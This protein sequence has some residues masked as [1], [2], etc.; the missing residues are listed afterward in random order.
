MATHKFNDTGYFTITLIAFN[1][2]CSDTLEK[3]HY[4]H[5]LPPTAKFTFENS[6]SD[7][8]SV[9]FKDKSL[10][11]LTWL[12]DFG[13]GDTSSLQNVSH[14]YA[15]PGKYN[16]K[17]YVTNVRRNKRIQKRDI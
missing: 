13:D 10:D 1:N 16:A 8:Q 14:F 3:Q 6:C 2:G 17:L 11:D 7:K 15:D 12:W 5:I 9:S 4:V